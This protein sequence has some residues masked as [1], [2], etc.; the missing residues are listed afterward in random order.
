MYTLIVFAVGIY[1]GWRF[2]DTVDGIMKRFI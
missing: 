1:V 2:A